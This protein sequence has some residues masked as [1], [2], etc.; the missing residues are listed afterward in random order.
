MIQATYMKLSRSISNREGKSSRDHAPMG[1]DTG[2][3]KLK[4][5]K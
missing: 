1:Q 2:F 4:F 3:D 5:K